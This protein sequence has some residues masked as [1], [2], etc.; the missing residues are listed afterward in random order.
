METAGLHTSIAIFNCFYSSYSIGTVF[1]LSFSSSM[2]TRVYIENQRKSD[3]ACKEERQLPP[4]SM[5]DP[6]GWGINW[7]FLEAPLI[8]FSYL[9]GD[10]VSTT[11]EWDR[12]VL[13]RYFWL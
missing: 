7:I 8:V 11:E 2:Q 3:V 13:H 4:D 6:R 10:D 1:F 5:L 12:V 9:F